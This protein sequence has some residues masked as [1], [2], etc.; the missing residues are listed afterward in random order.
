M[1]HSRPH[2]VLLGIICD[3]NDVVCFLFR[4][5]V[6]AEQKTDHILSPGNAL[7]SPLSVDPSSIF[8]PVTTCLAF[9]LES[10]RYH[11]LA[12]RR[13]RLCPREQP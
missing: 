11:H 3:D 7:A 13:T 6:E 2:I 12:D 10:H 8:S 9:Q 5:V 4:L 1:H